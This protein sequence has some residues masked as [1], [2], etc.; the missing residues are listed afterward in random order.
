M[1]DGLNRLWMQDG[2]CNQDPANEWC[3]TLFEAVKEARL[4]EGG[5]WDGCIL[6]GCC[7]ATTKNIAALRVGIDART[8]EK[9]QG[10]TVQ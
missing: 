7:K 1:W 10:G 4:D 8:C 3:D 2:E 6:G 5:P 9:G